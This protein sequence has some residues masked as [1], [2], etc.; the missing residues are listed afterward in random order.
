M[1]RCVFPFAA[2]LGGLLSSVAF[3]A[4]LGGR[5]YAPPSN[6]YYEQPAYR[7]EGLYIGAHGGL[8]FGKAFSVSSDRNGFVGGL[9]GGYNMQFGPAVAGVEIEG[10]YMGGAERLAGGVKLEQNWRVAGKGRLGLSFD[11]T[12]LFA[13]AGYAMTQF[14]APVGS[15]ISDGWKGGYLVGAGIEQA[16]AGGLS[17]KV[18]YNYAS[19]SG[20]K[21][22]LPFGRTEKADGGHLVKAGVNMRF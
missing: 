15:G 3:A 20:L 4:D 19:Y 8:A 11:R 18:E 1:V 5:S 6:P 7:W 14:D 2:V 10:S 22:V 13:T 16:F 9:Q 17:A 12:L 21:A